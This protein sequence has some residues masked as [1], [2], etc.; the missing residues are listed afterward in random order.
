MIKLKFWL[1]NW[2]NLMEQESFSYKLIL[3]PIW[4]HHQYWFFHYFKKIK[5]YNVLIFLFL[6]FILL[7]LKVYDDTIRERWGVTCVINVLTEQHLFV[8]EFWRY[9]FSSTQIPMNAFCLYHFGILEDHCCVSFV[10]FR[11]ILV[12]IEL[13]CQHNLVSRSFSRSISRVYLMVGWY[14]LRHSSNWWGT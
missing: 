4:K 3:W 5:W 13:F 8:V 2:W 11:C 6:S 7:M 14:L 1:V 10:R 12:L 9:T